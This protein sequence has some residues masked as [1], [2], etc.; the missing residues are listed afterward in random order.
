MDIVF[1][2]SMVN[3]VFAVYK[4]KSLQTIN[5]DKLNCWQHVFGR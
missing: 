4:S 3:F 1:D 5:L 2:T